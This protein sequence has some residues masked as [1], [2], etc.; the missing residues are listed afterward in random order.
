MIEK[1]TVKKD[2]SKEIGRRLCIFALIA[3][4]IAGTAPMMGIV[5][6][7]YAAE[8]TTV[9]ELKQTADAD[10]DNY[11]QTAEEVSNLKQVYEDAQAAKDS[12]QTAYDD[13]VTAYN[14][15]ESNKESAETAKAAAQTAKDDAQAAYDSAATKLINAAN[16]KL[17][18]DEEVDTAQAEYNE[19]KAAYDEAAVQIN[20]GSFGFFEEMGATGALNAL[21]REGNNNLGRP[22]STTDKDGK[23]FT[24]F[25]HPD[26]E[27]DATSL[28]NMKAA[29][30]YIPVGNALRI[31][32]DLFPGCDELLVSDTLMAMAQSDT[33]WSDSHIG[34][35]DQNGGNYNVG[36]NLAWGW[37]GYNPYEGWYDDEKMVYREVTSQ[38]DINGDGI[39][40]D[41]QDNITGHYTNLVKASFKSTGFAINTKGSLYPVTCGQTF[42]GG[43]YAGEPLYTV[44]DYKERFMTYY[45]SVKVVPETNLANAETALSTAK[46]NQSNAQ[47]AYDNAVNER[48]AAQTALNSAVTALTEAEANLTEANS[49]FD[50]A[51]T[52]KNKI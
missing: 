2:I 10:K 31:N 40:G 17:Q 49:Q 11:E 28:E 39:I 9:L 22:L 45:N 24:S 20:K 35:A 41:G 32:D 42:S 23:L 12:A 52:L 19:A 27:R 25:T 3:A 50:A 16:E 13:A 1:T 47:T 18:A 44:S 8:G 51:E 30:D 14:T 15:A 38:T 26:D 5:P 29:I 7:A 36:E 46:T 6:N 21:N 48:D 34:H 37:K 4:L 33:N 43:A